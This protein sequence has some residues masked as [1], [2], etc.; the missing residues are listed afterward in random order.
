[1]LWRLRDITQSVR[2]PQWRLPD[3][4]GMSGNAARTPTYALSR[5]W[6]SL[7]RLQYT[8][9]QSQDARG[10]RG[11]FAVVGRNH[12]AGTEAPIE[13][14]HQRKDFGRGLVAPLAGR[15]I[16]QHARRLGDQRARNF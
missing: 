5:A 9:D 6:R 12:E 16:G 3:A 11:D 14:E 13:L 1:M 8:I 2:L 10:V 15:F 7:S 4:W